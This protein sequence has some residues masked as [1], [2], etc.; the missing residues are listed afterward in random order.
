MPFIANIAPHLIHLSLIG[1]LNDDIHVV[2]YEIPQDRLIHIVQLSFFFL[3]SRSRLLDSPSTHVPY[4]ECHFRSVPY[5]Q[6]G[7]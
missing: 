1:W 7:F 2:W 6:S 3:M 5:R 4:L